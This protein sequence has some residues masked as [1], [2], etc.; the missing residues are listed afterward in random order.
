MIF[1]AQVC[2]E[3]PNGVHTCDE[4]ISRDNN[5]LPTPVAN[6]LRQTGNSATID[7]MPTPATNTCLFYDKDA[8]A[9]DECVVTNGTAIMHIPPRM[10]E[11][12]K[13]TVTTK[14]T[15]PYTLLATEDEIVLCDA[16]SNAI[17]LNLPAAA[18]AGSG[19]RYIV[20][21]IDAT[22]RLCTIDANGTEKID[23]ELTQ[24]LS[25]PDTAIQLLTNGSN[26]FI[27]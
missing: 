27:Y 25:Q 9:T 18:S 24:V 7:V 3:S 5:A 19:R 13:A 10:A 12:P 4:H 8:T 11:L 23:G 6:A 20:K 2:V 26:W 14:T 15:T 16:T 1:A 17:T 22:A 21:K